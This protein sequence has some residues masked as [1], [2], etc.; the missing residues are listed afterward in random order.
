MNKWLIILYFLF[1]VCFT[2]FSY[3]FI[4]P[5]FIYLRSFYTGFATSNRLFVTILYVFFIVCFFLFYWL[6]L[7]G[8]KKKLIEKKDIV[9]LVFGSLAILLFSYPAILS[10]DLFNYIATAKVTFFYHE[11]PYVT[12]P[13]E[14]LNDPIL[15]FTHAANK[16][17]LYGPLW[18]AI[19]TVPFALG[20]GNYLVS[21]L[22]FKLLVIV[23]YI[24]TAILIWKISRNL[25]SVSFFAL[26]PLVLIETVVSG[27]NDIVMIFLALFAFSFFFKKKT[28]FSLMAL[29]L[30]IFVKYATLFLVPFLPYIFWKTKIKGK[31]IKKEELF[32]LSASAMFI[33]FLLSPIREEI[34]PWYAIWFLTFVSFLLS[35]K[36]VMF[37]S[38]VFSFFLLLR[39]TPFM[40]YGIHYGNTPLIKTIFTFTPLASF[41]LYELLFKR[42]LFGK[43]SK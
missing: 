31:I 8:V 33:V 10:F 22:T 4:D 27:H 35:K 17:A 39:Y 3:L 36:A 28:L 6:F 21:I 5:N 16:I 13:I 11:N 37:Y 19:T 24:G 38:I 9:L 41:V 15:L 42:V 32:F 12:M 7:K 18:I 26:N 30:S 14:F 23:F 40:L 2:G 34:Y 43:K 25:F 1:L 29:L 20:M